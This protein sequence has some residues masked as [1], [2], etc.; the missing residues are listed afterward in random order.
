MSSAAASSN[1]AS[2]TYS[3]APSGTIVGETDT[4]TSSIS[5]A[6]YTYDPQSRVTQ[7]TPG[8]SGALNYSY[9]ASS[10]LTMLPTGASTTYDHAGELTSSTLSSTTTSY[11]YNSDGELTAATG[12]SSTAASVGWTG[13]GELT[14][15]SDAA[16]D[17]SAATYD[18]DGLRTAATTTPTGGSASTQNF[19]WDVTSQVPSLLM[20]STSA[21]IYGP[22][23]TPI[24]Q[25]DL[26]TGAVTY[27][28]SDALGSVR[29]VL[30]SSGSLVASTSYDAYGNPE[31]TGGLSSYTPFGFAGGYT[32]P[33]GLVY[34]IGRYYDPETGQFLSVDPLVD[35]TGEPYGYANGNPVNESDPAG[36]VGVP[37][38]Y[39][40]CAEYQSTGGFGQCVKRGLQEELLASEC[41]YGVWNCLV[42][43]LDPAY[44][45]ISG[46]YNA[47]EAAQ[48][49]CSSNWQMAGDSFEALLGTVGTIASGLGGGALADG[50]IG[51]GGT[52]SELLTNLA[53]EA[54]TSVGVGGGPAY[55]TAVH[56]AFAAEIDALGDTNLSTEVSYLGGKV[57]PYGAPGS[58]R[59]DVV[60]G[61]LLKPT[62]IYDLKTGNAT[63]SPARIEQIRANLPA[64]S[65][66]IPVKEIRP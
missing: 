66:G 56:S 48:N 62:A 32:D 25:V 23:G 34:L 60:E 35:E 59:L 13:A 28:A 45:A 24:E 64:G 2:F 44:T 26:S 63:L 14:S 1:L 49:P 33:T 58:V 41:P 31:T 54:Q 29:G 20:D 46:A 57:V 30:S 3:R 12:S 43:A 55:G 47:Y 51:T 37:A 36:S 50:L 21:Y 11:T 65:Q 22:S 52:T 19:V 61:N 6:S 42:M 8:S 5:P 39:A 18:G 4:P 27:L 17:T 53:S 9:D 7:M 10:N 15:Y 40:N 16:A 38:G